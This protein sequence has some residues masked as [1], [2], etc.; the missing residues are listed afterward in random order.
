M[1]LPREKRFY[2]CIVSCGSFKNFCSKGIC[3]TFN[4]GRSHLYLLKATL[5]V[6]IYQEIFSPMADSDVQLVERKSLEPT[7]SPASEYHSMHA[8]I[9]TTR[10]VS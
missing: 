8:H 1:S 6:L 2:I 7:V 3:L 10:T 4:V 5:Y 9:M